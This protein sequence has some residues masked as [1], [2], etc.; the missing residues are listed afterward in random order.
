[1]VAEP[2]IEGR[3]TEGL[4][5]CGIEV[6]GKKC[7]PWLRSSRHI[8]ARSRRSSRHLG[9]LKRSFT[10]QSARTVPGVDAPFRRE[11]SHLL[12]GLDAIG[13]T[14]FQPVD[15]RKRL[16]GVTRQRAAEPPRADAKSQGLGTLA[17]SDDYV[18]VDPC[19][20]S[21]QEIVNACCGADRR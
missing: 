20:A 1:M 7:C 10:T 8:M 21:C 19:E 11:S 12:M 16:T 15:D 2:Y 6:E 17:V 13:R 4:S 9:S 14:R 5:T 3:T 18:Q